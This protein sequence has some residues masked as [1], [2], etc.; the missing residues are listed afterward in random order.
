MMADLRI[1]D[2]D[3]ISLT[4]TVSEQYDEEQEFQVDRV[5]AE[6]TVNGKNYYLLSWEDY[7]EEASTWEP[8]EH[9]DESIIE[10][11]RERQSLERSAG[12]FRFDV[13]RLELKQRRIAEEKARRHARRNEKRKRLGIPISSTGSDADNADDSESSVEER[14]DI[15]DIS[16]RRTNLKRKA[17]PPK[18]KARVPPVR[19]FTSGTSMDQF[20]GQKVPKS[21]SS[22]IEPIVGRS[23]STSNSVNRTLDRAQNSRTTNSRS[24]STGG[25][26][27]TTLEVRMINFELRL[28]HLIADIEMTS[29]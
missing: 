8:E 27:N 23:Y 20:S 26:N 12:F 5:L 22:A 17:T 7:P 16:A 6:K 10:A 15:D 11:W 24:S 1:R 13:K 25:G 9:I 3:E 19:V 2:D 18:Q 21:P 28:T 4:S 29:C 14:N